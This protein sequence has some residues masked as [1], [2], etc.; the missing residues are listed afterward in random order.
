MSEPKH[1]LVIRLSAMGDVA[2]TIPVLK[3]FSET[4]PDVKLTVVSRAFFKP[5]FADIPNLNFLEAD[6]YGKHKGVSGLMRLA[7]EA[8]VRDIDAVADLH[9]VLR[10]KIIRNYLKFKGIKTAYIDKGRNEKKALTRAKNK[11]FKPLKTT[12]ERYA[13]VFKQLGFP[14]DLNRFSPTFKKTL[15][16]KILGLAQIKHQKIIGIAPFAAHHGKKYPL[17]NMKKVLQLLDKTKHYHILLF[18]GGK[19]EVEILNDLSQEFSTVINIAGKLSFTEEL[20]VISNLDLMVSMDSGNGHLAAI[21]GVPVL[22][23]WGVTHPYAGF[24]PF[25]QS[26]NLQILAN[27]EKF[28]EIPTSIYGNKY[29][30][31]YEKAMETIQPEMIFEKI[32]EVM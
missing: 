3:V 26:E 6:V 14:L 23:L 19:K 27:R 8:L 22:T 31:G 16:P 32:C 18:G 30:E 28:P 29:P 11:V 12:H 24:A 1:I 25:K 4:Y 20:D 9:N 10:S 5:L 7:K 2:M 21:F 17:A 15:S 13:D